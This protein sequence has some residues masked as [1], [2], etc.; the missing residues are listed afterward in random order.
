MALTNPVLTV[1]STNDT[2]HITAVADADKIALQV[3]Q[4]SYVAPPL[5][6]TL[7]VFPVPVKESLT[8]TFRDIREASIENISLID[9]NGKVL[10]DHTIPVLSGSKTVVDMQR[11]PPGIYLLRVRGKDACRYIKVIRN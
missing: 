3:E 1:G 4:V 9:L 2:L 6:G 5:K 8:I 7:E 10:Y 11:F